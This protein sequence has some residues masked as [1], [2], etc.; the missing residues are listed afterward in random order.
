CWIKFSQ[1]TKYNSFPNMSPPPTPPPSPELPLKPIPGSYGIPFISAI[2]DRQN[3]FYHGGRDEFFKTLIAKHNNSTVVRT[4]MPPGPFIAGDPRVIA[5]L[6]SSSFPVLFDTSKVEKRNVLDGTYFP[7]VSFT[8]GRRMLAFLDPSEPKH[9]AVK[10]LVMSFLKMKSGDFVPLFRDSLAKMF[11][12]VD[13]EFVK[14][15]KVGFNGFG[16]DMSFRF[17]FR[18]F[19]DGK[20]PSE[21]VIGTRGPTIV[22]KWLALQLA[23]LASTRTF[24]KF[25]SFIEDFFLRTFP[26]PSFIV[27]SDYDDLYDAFYTHATS[28][29]DL[30]VESF[31]IERDEACHNLVFIAGFNAFGAMK[32]LFPSLLK[33]VA[34]AGIKLQ[35]DLAHEIRTVVKEEGGKVI[36]SASLDKMTLTKSVVY[37]VLRID[38]P[39]PF[40][41]G[42]A[43][44]DMV[45]CSHDAS[46]QVKKG[47]MLF[48]YQPFA[49]KDPKVFDIAEEFVG[50]RFMDIEGEK[51]L[52][53]MYWSNGRETEDPTVENKQC[54][55]KDLVV[56]MSRLFLAEFFLKYDGLTVEFDTL[57]FLGWSVTITSLIKATTTV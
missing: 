34:G 50:E 39:V 36:N 42:K 53:Y 52:R 8:G 24:P 12:D 43:K 46:F 41:Y 4:N 2:I 22:N 37:E 48:G 16:D 54:P 31:G 40:Q 47:E 35:H 57:P 51:M 9:D 7:S 55:A 26:F 25:L 10:S 21:T 29:L 1:I 5:L 6:D 18:L 11:A 19:C 15:G 14:D 3:Y 20:D 17:L 38:P 49:T 23:P 45:V 27:Q 32:S 13:A 30:A 56:L 28:F 44:Q 33:W